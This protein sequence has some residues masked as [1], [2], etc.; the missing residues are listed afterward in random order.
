V[1]PVLCPEERLLYSC[2][3]E[4]CRLSHRCPKRNPGRKLILEHYRTL[5]THLVTPS[6]V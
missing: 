5:K 6:F 2:L 3:V 1:V 4:W